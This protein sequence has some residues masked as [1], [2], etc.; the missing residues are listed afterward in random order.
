MTVINV[1]CSLTG[2]WLLD[3][4]WE[5]QP[6]TLHL[7]LSACQLRSHQAVSVLFIISSLYLIL[8][9][10]GGRPQHF[11]PRSL[12]LGQRVDQS[13][14]QLEQ[15]GSCAIP[16]TSEASVWGAAVSPVGG[17]WFQLR[18]GRW[19]RRGWRV[20]GRWWCLSGQDRLHVPIWKRSPTS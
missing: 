4:T 6:S 12:E 13:A 8:C 2:S 20:N 11:S 5:N 1:V 3:Q 17:G 14:F 18:R 7:L 15:P 19:G 16:Q 9:L 10:L